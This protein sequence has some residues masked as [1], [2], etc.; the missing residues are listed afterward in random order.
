MGLL[1]KS[2]QRNLVGTDLLK[3][4]RILRP[5]EYPSKRSYKARNRTRI[6]AVQSTELTQVGS[7]RVPRRATLSGKQIA[8]VFVQ[9]EIETVCVFYQLAH[10]DIQRCVVRFFLRHVFF[11]IKGQ[12]PVERAMQKQEAC[13]KFF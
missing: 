8:R 4:Q 5:P 3:A 9:F 10:F 7:E 12:M 11:D 6:S 2:C 1:V 13:I